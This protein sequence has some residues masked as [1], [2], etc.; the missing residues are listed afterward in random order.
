MKN[1][2]TKC[3]SV[4][5]LMPLRLSGGAGVSQN[6]GF[7]KR[8]SLKML[9]ETIMSPSIFLN[10]II[11]FLITVTSFCELSHIFSRVLFDRIVIL[12]LTET[13]Y[14]EIH[15]YDFHSRVENFQ[16]MSE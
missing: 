6:F 7:T 16:K 11:Q 15:A 1:N 13:Y 12:R 2:S 14:M 4:N 3:N 5:T 10:R 9:N 8:G